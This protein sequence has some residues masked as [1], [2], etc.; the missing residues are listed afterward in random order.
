[1]KKIILILTTLISLQNCSQNKD[2]M[3]NQNQQIT[4][5]NIVEEI[6]K[7]VKHYPNEPMYSFRQYS[8]KCFFEIYMD[9]IL[10]AKNFDNLLTDSFDINKVLFKSGAHQVKYKLYALGSNNIYNTNYPTL[11]DDTDF[12]LSLVSYDQKNDGA[13][14]VEHYKYTLPKI[15][16]KVN[17][18]YST[19]KFEG[20]GKPSY[21][22]TFD[23]NVD[24]PFK[25]N[26]PFAKAQDLRNINAKEIE[27]K[28]LAKYKEVS[29]VYQGKDY[30]NIARMEFDALRNLY[31]SN[32]DSKE[33]INE[34]WQEYLKAYKSSSF[35][36]QPLVKYKLQFFANGKMA[37]LMLDTNDNRLRGNTALW[38]KVDYDGG[39]RP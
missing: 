37:A 11:V 17:E 6:T 29:Q 21:E 8:F 3:I 36:M 34:N 28:L 23:I 10:F 13:D 1:M 25:I 14:D 35:Q 20:S 12:S 4:V 7:E 38:A 30:D 19:Y 26:A 27:S 22:G 32:Y 18:N 33:I 16:T 39:L 15:E 31:V 5:D 2:N 24:V 9:D